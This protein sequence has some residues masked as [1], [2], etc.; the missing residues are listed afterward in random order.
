VIFALKLMNT[1][2]M[3]CFIL[4]DSF[5]ETYRCSVVADVLFDAQV[6][7]V[8]SLFSDRDFV[9]YGVVHI[10]FWDELT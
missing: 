10:V 3:N 7:S 1:V 9:L 8:T 6:W 4:G 2:A 5:R